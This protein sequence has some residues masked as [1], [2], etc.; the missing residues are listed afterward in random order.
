MTR[1]E[2][3][4]QNLKDRRGFYPSDFQCEDSQYSK[5][6]D[7][8][9]AG[10]DAALK[11]DERVLALIEALEFY[12]SEGAGW[13]WHHCKKEFVR[14]NKCFAVSDAIN[15]DG[16]EEADKALKKWRGEV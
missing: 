14:D 13:N 3:A 9:K 2:M 6:L 12:S 1:D 11:H 8:F 7:T 15:L 16:G 5:E 4:K 10:W